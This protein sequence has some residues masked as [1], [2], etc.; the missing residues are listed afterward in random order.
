MSFDEVPSYQS[1]L[2]KRMKEVNEELDAFRG[3]VDQAEELAASFLAEAGVAYDLIE[4]AAVDA[5]NVT[6]V[7]DEVE[8]AVE[9]FEEALRAVGSVEKQVDANEGEEDLRAALAEVN[10]GLGSLEEAYGTAVERSPDVTAGLSELRDGAV[11]VND[12]AGS[13]AGNLNDA[14]AANGDLVEGLGELVEG[15]NELHGSVAEISDYTNELDPGRQHELMLSSPIESLSTE[16]ESEYSYGEGLTPY[17]LSI[18]LYVGALTLS[19][20]YPF[21]E[22]LGPHADGREWFAGKF[23]VVMIVG[24]V[25]VTILLAFILIGLDLDVSSPGAFVAFTYLVSLVFMSMIFMLVGVLDNPGRFV[26][27]ILLILQL[28]GSGGTFPVELLASPLQTIHGWLP[29]T[30]SVL[31]FRSVVFMDSPVLLWQ[32]VM[33]LICVAVV[34]LVIAFLFYVK[35]Y[36]KLCAPSI[37]KKREQTNG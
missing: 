36:K 5:G 7:L 29:M 23:G 24:F 33:F 17:F 6:R 32:S 26:A 10:E 28:G 34:V 15:S 22:H 2:Q 12:G 11:R 30:Y 21:R 9:T 14:A 18:G 13:I 1:S 37:D 27:I 35:F 3:N 16:S 25:Q 4:G 20:I 19:I 31:G 8:Q